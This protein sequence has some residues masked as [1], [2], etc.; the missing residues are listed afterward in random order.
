MLVLVSYRS[1]YRLLGTCKYSK[2]MVKVNKYIACNA[3]VKIKLK[4]SDI[5][6]GDKQ[7]NKVFIYETDKKGI[8]N[9]E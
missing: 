7:G 1:K 3:V 9:D 8:K 5:P 2:E 6:L 4:K